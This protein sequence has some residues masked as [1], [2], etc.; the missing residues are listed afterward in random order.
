MALKWQ[1]KNILWGGAAEKDELGSSQAWFDKYSVSH[2]GNGFVFTQIMQYF[3]KNKY[4]ALFVILLLHI[5]EDYLENTA[6]SL[7]G[8]LGGIVKRNDLFERRDTDSLQNF[9]GD[10]IAFFCG[11]LIAIHTPLL[12]WR[13]LL[14]ALIFTLVVLPFLLAKC[15]TPR[16][17]RS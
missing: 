14:V 15:W 2:F 16:G 1:P 10:N 17:A 9:I 5:V 12:D 3:I 13:I 7:E 4:L 8:I 11:G 6:V